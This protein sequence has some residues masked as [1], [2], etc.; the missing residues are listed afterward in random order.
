MTILRLAESSRVL[1]SII[2]DE[3][4]IDTKIRELTYRV[5]ELILSNIIG[6]LLKGIAL[7][8]TCDLPNG[9]EIS[10]KGGDCNSLISRANLCKD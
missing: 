2:F 1:S 8:P 5:R 7:E 9:S 4:F 6:F 3:L 10:P